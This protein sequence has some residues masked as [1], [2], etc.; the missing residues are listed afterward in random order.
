M[1]L[2]FHG[3][4][5]EPEQIR[6]RL[7]TAKIGGSELV[8]CAKHLG[9]MAR[10]RDRA[11]RRVLPSA[12]GVRSTEPQTPCDPSPPAVEGPDAERAPCLRLPCR[13][14]GNR[15]RATGRPAAAALVTKVKTS[16]WVCGVTDFNR[17]SYAKDTC[18]SGAS[19]PRTEYGNYRIR[20]RQHRWAVSRL[21][22]RSAHRAP[23]LLR[24]IQS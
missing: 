11:I 12:R 8:R 5:A 15:R 7:G 16:V 20:P 22:E 2:R 13:R 6:H 9:L 24:R 18:E 23:S 1:L 10:A 14:S 3:V 17:L 4:G 19:F 21:P